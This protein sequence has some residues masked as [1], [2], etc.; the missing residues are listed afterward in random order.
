VTPP[1][2]MLAE[3][4][5]TAM[6]AFLVFAVTDGRNPFRLG[7]AMTAVPIGLAVAVLISIIA[8]LTQA[9]LNPARDFGPRLFAYM[10]GWGPVA[11]PGPRGGFF[12]V[13]ILAPILGA[14]V[15]AGLYQLLLH[16]AVRRMAD[17]NT[18]EQQGES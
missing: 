11:I 18:S 7:T 1:R 14:L 10:A 2:A 3:G 15:G 12:T 5:G 16:P 6:L 8:P 17:V 13:Y 9:G 4:L